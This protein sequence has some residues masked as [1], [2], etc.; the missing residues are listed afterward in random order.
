M[1]A[2]INTSCDNCGAAIRR[3]RDKVMR[4]NRTGRGIYCGSECA[5]FSNG[6]L[7]DASSRS[8]DI[9]RVYSTRDGLRV[10]SLE[11]TGRGEFPLAGMV[12]VKGE[13]AHH[14]WTP[15]G[16]F[17]PGRAQHGFDLVEDET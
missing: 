14:R 17:G 1:S 9:E 2:R 12:M 8:I 3:S 15:D 7:Q 13:R 4:A 16:S 10:V 11:N 5:G 6:R